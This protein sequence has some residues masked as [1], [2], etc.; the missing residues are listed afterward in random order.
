MTRDNPGDD[1]ERI[2]AR[3]N[4]SSAQQRPIWNDNTELSMSTATWFHCIQMEKEE[5][6]KPAR[7]PGVSVLRPPWP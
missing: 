5:E 3:N 2:G 6:G 1:L 4:S 7:A